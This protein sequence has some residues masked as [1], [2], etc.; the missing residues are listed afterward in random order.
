ML[1]RGSAL[2][3]QEDSLEPLAIRA[4][5]LETATQLALAGRPEL[6]ALSEGSLAYTAL[7]R[8]EAASSLPDIFALGDVSA[9]YTPGRDLADSRYVRDPLN[10]F[11]PALLVG[12][13]WHLEPGMA[14]ERASEQRAQG[15]RLSELR[16]FASSGIPAEV[17]RA[18]EDIQRATQDIAQSE[19]GVQSTKAW[20]VRASADYSIGLGDSREV[21]D[22]ARAYVELRMS[23]LDAIRR[24]NVALAALSR[25]T[26]TLTSN[27][28]FYPTQ[29]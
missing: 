22:A 8:A 27:A 14:E 1:P 11:Y 12:V 23:S 17:V 7:A 18:L 21:T 10:G 13:R 2:N 24:H 3:L 29:N 25:A 19:Q 16:R 15:L 4:P 5:S 28:T 20:M 6:R 9:A 26:G